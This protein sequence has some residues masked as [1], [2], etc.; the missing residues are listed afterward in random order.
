[1]L[2]Y[3]LVQK[4]ANALSNLEQSPEPQTAKEVQAMKKREDA[5]KP[6]T[7][8]VVCG[9]LLHHDDKDVKLLVAICVTE[10]F[11]VKAPKPPFEDM[12]LRVLVNT[13]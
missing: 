5:L 13:S 8:V 2:F 7:D 4:A 9:S 11:R 12:Y 1:L 10:L 6:L 3:A